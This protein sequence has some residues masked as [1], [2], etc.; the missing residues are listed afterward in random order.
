[1]P[2][3]LHQPRKDIKMSINF[4]HQI[5]EKI[6]QRPVYEMTK[7]TTQLAVGSFLAYGI[8]A[9]ALGVYSVPVALLIGMALCL[10]TECN[11]QQQS[12]SPSI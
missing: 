1:M 10:V 4:F 6:E 11:A 2:L 9:L 3:K 12:L 7:R 8:L 5:K